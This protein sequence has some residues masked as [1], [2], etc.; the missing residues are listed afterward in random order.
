MVSRFRRPLIEW[1]RNNPKLL[2]RAIVFF[3]AGPSSDLPGDT[4]LELMATRFM[5][6]CHTLADVIRLCEQVN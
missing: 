1:P 3:L 4:I 5:R 6:E 2:D